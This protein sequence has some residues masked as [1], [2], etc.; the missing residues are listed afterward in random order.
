MWRVIAWDWNGQLLELELSRRMR[1]QLIPR[2]AAKAITAT[3]RAARQVRCER[4]ARLV[5]AA[6][7]G[8]VVERMSLSR[9]PKPGQPGR[10]AQVLLKTRRERVAVVGP[11]VSSAPA[12][13]DAFLSSSLLWFRRAAVQQLWLIVSPE[14]L[15]PLLYRVVLLRPWLKEIIRVFTVDED[16][17]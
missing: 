12:A 11:V 16:L 6:C 10:Y 4:L 15:K 17:T 14:L 2:T 9:G 3:I 13:V 5:A 1:I 8:S 7:F